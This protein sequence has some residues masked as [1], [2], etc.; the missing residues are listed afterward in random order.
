MDIAGLLRRSDLQGVGGA[1]LD[2]ERAAVA[3]LCVNDGLLPIFL[4]GVLGGSVELVAD[5][6]VFADVAAGA[7][8]DAAVGVDLVHL[9]H[10]AG[11]CSYGTDLCA[12]VAALAFI[13]YFM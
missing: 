6:L 11:D 10:L 7:A 13:G 12:V 3:E 8:V 9:L 2:A 1:V 5:T 4:G